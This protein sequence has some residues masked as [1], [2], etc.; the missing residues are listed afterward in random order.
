M[1]WVRGKS[2]GYGSFATVNIATPID[3]RSSTFPPLM[4]VKSC[5]VELSE[6]LKHE[7][8]TLDQIGYC[9][10]IIQCFGDDCTTEGDKLYNIFLEYASRGSLADLVKKTGCGLSESC[11]KT[12][13]NSVLKALCFIH[14]KGFAHCDIKLDNILVCENGE[15]KVADFGLATKKGQF[16]GQSRGTPLYMSPESL[17][18]NLYEPSCDI[19]AL[20][21]AVYEMLTGITV[22]ASDKKCNV[23]ALLMKIGVGNE[24]P[25][26]LSDLSTDGQDF[27]LKCFVRDPSKR[28]TAEMLL[29]HPFVQVNGDVLKEERF[30]ISPRSPFGFP[31]TKT[32]PDSDVWASVNFNGDTLTERIGRLVCDEQQEVNW[33][34]S[35]NWVTVRL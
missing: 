17:N 18:E 12:Y 25:G 4:A 10:Q 29:N 26:D 28:W 24:L 35:D 21:C 7:K 9:P 33:S 8:Q 32:T 11:V 27:L 2:I 34:D 1:N 20:G 3:H 22:W 30:T 19:W 15:A 23:G 6:T 5:V 31:S 13:T 16:N 14:S